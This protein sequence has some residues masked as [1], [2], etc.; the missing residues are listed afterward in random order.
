MSD[1]LDGY[2]VINEIIRRDP[3]PE[4]REHVVVFTPETAKQVHQRISMNKPFAGEVRALTSASEL[5]QYV[6]QVLSKLAATMDQNNDGKEMYY[7]FRE[8]Y[9]R[10]AVEGNMR[11]P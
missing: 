3:K 4:I 1:V 6:R 5:P 7:M 8:P 2:V 9:H 10:Q 11:T